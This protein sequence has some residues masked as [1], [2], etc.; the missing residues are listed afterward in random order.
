[1]IVLA[2]RTPITLWSDLCSGWISGQEDWT[3]EA[4]GA[5]YVSYANL[6]TCHWDYRAMDSEGITLLRDLAAQKASATNGAPVAEEVFPEKKTYVT[7]D[8]P[9]LLNLY[10]VGLI[11]FVKK[12]TGEVQVHVHVTTV[13]AV[14]EFAELLFALN[15]YFKAV[16]VP[17]GTTI[18]F[19]VTR[20]TL[21]FFAMPLLMPILGKRA[22]F[23]FQLLERLNRDIRKLETV[24]FKEEYKNKAHQEVWKHVVQVMGKEN[25]R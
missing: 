18:V 11:E 23:D 24:I 20:M 13:D 7:W 10:R 4:G 15:E 9:T 1:M 5:R 14:R 21:S 25:T 3:E 17:Q 6:L 16:K 8:R 2:S 22:F 12:H 19:Q